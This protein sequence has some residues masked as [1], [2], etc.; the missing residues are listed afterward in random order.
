ME[1][2]LTVKN[3]RWGLDKVVEVEDFLILAKEYLKKHSV[4]YMRELMNSNAVPSFVSD[5]LMREIAYSLV[6]TGEYDVQEWGHPLFPYIEILV[7]SKAPKRF[8][9][10]H[11]FWFA[12]IMAFIGA[13]FALGGKILSELPAKQSQHQLDQRQ[14]STIQ[15]LSDSLT[16]YQNQ[17]NRLIADTTFVRK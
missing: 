16:N 11:P 13:L 4:L 17:L 2:K 10:K 3:P 12:V 8:N 14:D 9:E 5:K 15:A 1:Q 7:T 6:K